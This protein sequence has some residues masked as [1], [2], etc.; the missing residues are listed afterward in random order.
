MYSPFKFQ[1]NN[2]HF[3]TLMLRSI[4]LMITRW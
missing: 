2:F 1:I 3:V 4:E